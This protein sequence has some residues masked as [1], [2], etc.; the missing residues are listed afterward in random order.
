[1]DDAVL[2]SLSVSLEELEENWHE[3]LRKQV[4]WLTYLSMNLYQILFLLGA[5]MTIIGFIRYRRKKR[6]QADWEDF[7]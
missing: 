1:M 3:H 5:V 4:P 2:W 6:R 7:E